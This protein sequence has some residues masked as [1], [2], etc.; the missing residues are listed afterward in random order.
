MFNDW[1]WSGSGSGSGNTL[2]GHSLDK[3]SRQIVAQRHRGTE[4][5]W[6]LL[7]PLSHTYKSPDPNKCPSAPRCP[8]PLPYLVLDIS[9]KLRFNLT[10]RW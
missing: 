8:I 2:G 7:F 1:E 9:Q 4:A 3:R 6:G 5:H 10:D